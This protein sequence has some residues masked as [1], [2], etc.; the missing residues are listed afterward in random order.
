MNSYDDRYAGQQAAAGSQQS[1]GL[2]EFTRSLRAPERGTV[3]IWVLLRPGEGYQYIV[4][5]YPSVPELD[6]QY[7]VARLGP[8]AWEKG[9]GLDP[10]RIILANGAREADRQRQ[11]DHQNAMLQRMVANRVDQYMADHKLAEC[12]PPAP[13]PA[14]MWGPTK[15]PEQ[16]QDCTPSEPRPESVEGKKTQCGP[17][18]PT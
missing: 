5:D 6:M 11:Q 9:Q 4:G 12:T 18:W 17:R 10:F 14:V 2:G 15:Q 1:L 13:A 7:V 16:G 8:F 3:L